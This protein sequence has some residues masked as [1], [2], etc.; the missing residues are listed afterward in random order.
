MSIFL[1][2]SKI[3]KVSI[4]G[5]LVNIL[6]EP[7]VI[8]PKSSYFFD[9]YD[10]YLKAIRTV[11]DDSN[12]Y[13]IE[14]SVESF[15]EAKLIA[16]SASSEE[17][18]I[19]DLDTEKLSNLI[20]LIE[21]KYAF[22]CFD[23]EATGLNIYS[24]S[25]DIRML[26]I[27]IEYNES[28]V[29]LFDTDREKKIKLLKRLFTLKKV[30]KVAHNLQFDAKI[31]KRYDIDIKHG[32]ECTM[33]MANQLQIDKEIGLK[34]LRAKFFP[35][36]PAYE[37]VMKKEYKVAMKKEWK[38]SVSYADCPIYILKPYAS[39]DTAYTF[40]FYCYF[41]RLLCNDTR[42][43]NDYN[44]VVVPFLNVAINTLSQGMLVDV[45]ILEVAREK[46]VALLE[47][48]EKD[49]DSTFEVSDWNREVIEN[50]EKEFE[51][52]ISSYDGKSKEAFIV[53][54]S[55]KLE[56][57]IVK[58]SLNLGSPKQKLAF[59]KKYFNY[60]H[61]STNA[62]L[63]EVWLADTDYD[64]EFF[65]VMAKI[66]KAGKLLNTNILPLIEYGQYDGYVRSTYKIGGTI[67]GRLS[68]TDPNLQ[69]LDK[70]ER[71]A[72][73]EIRELAALVKKSFICKDGWGIAQADL[74]Q[75]E[76][77]IMAYWSK[78]QNLL[79]AYRE[80]KDVHS[81]T[82][83]NFM[84][85]S[86]EDFMK[87]EKEERA[88]VRDK[89]KPVNFGLIFLME[90]TGLMRNAALNYKVFMTKDEAQAWIDGF[91]SIY[92]EIGSYHK[93]QSKRAAMEGYAETFFGR[94]SK[95]D[96]KNTYKKGDR[97]A[98]NRKAVNIPTQGT[99]AE[100]VLLL[101][102]ILDDLDLDWVRICNS[103]HDSLIVY[104]RQ[105]Y[106]EELIKVLNIISEYMPIDKWFGDS[107]ISSSGKKNTVKM[108]LD[109]KFGSS[110][111]DV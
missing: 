95:L 51:A 54:E 85:L 97:E 1:V 20:N 2:S 12:C 96:Y 91:F 28:Y 88:L 23:F 9:D 64:S 83:S 49:F 101:M 58:N 86:Y 5:V 46:A 98:L 47:I 41:N 93:H 40:V 94:K 65:K 67:T 100:F 6:L 31:L 57:A 52:K 105:G 16:S 4:K 10:T 82:A 110:W 72:D 42:L 104:V 99:S 66:A 3:T 111:H 50:L 78:C 45:S 25:F 37:D 21:A 84:K 106:R 90:A 14:G 36:A 38:N 34:E 29:L 102:I 13:M 48:L 61:D 108:V 69:N 74:S 79:T 55:L 19:I 60:P 107:F 39:T 17:V 103:V 71:I 27:S 77:R 18:K 75:A 26:S 24:H 32:L 44:T 92:K 76:L 63:M 70:H 87:I 89:A 8:E 53:K 81:L 22:F 62:K 33:L 109:Y 15:I 59:L 30:K 68:S 80:N 7:P 35:N 56:K 11:E 43:L 73:P